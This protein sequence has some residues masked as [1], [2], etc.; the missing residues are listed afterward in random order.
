MVP[1]SF[2]EYEQARKAG[3]YGEPKEIR[4]EPNFISD[5]HVHDKACFVYVV[6]GEFRLKTENHLEHHPAG[7]TCLLPEHTMHA[8]LAGPG[9]ATILVAQRTD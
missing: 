3:G 6:E 9:G 7:H 5:M 2:E 1:I 8:E 4:Y